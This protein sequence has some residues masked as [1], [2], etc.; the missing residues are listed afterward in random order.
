MAKKVC[1]LFT[2]CILVLFG[3]SFAGCNGGFRAVYS[4]TFTTVQGQTITE[5]TKT[6]ISFDTLAF[7][8]RNTSEYTDDI[9]R[10]KPTHT[11]NSLL[12]PQMNFLAMT[13]M[14]D[15]VTETSF[16]GLEKKDIGTTFCHIQPSYDS[17]TIGRLTDVYCNYVHVKEIDDHTIIIDK[18]LRKN[19]KGAKTTYTV[20]SYSVSYM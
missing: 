9:R 11:F 20:T 4:V 7:G 12:A 15:E 10:Y 3:F 6:A 16:F 8:D 5:V 18:S 17:Y 19:G 14:A 13:I 1:A 2:A